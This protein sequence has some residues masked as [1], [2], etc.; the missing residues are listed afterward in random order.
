M[1]ERDQILVAVKT[2]LMPRA[3]TFLLPG[4]LTLTQSLAAIRAVSPKDDNAGIGF[5]RDAGQFQRVSLK[6]GYR[7]IE[8]RFHVVMS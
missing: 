6:V 1:E 5:R 4:H 2:P 3:A 7:M 8:S